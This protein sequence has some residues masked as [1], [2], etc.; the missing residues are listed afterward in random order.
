MTLRSLIALPVLL[1]A[2]VA[3]GCGDEE[4]GSPIPAG[5]AA[6]L[7]DQLDGIQR[8]LDNGSAGACN[9][10]LG[11]AK[12]PNTEAV[13]QQLA[14]LPED[15]DADVRDALQQSFDRLFELIDEHC[16]QLQSEQSDPQPGP[17]PDP[18]P[19]PDTTPEEE[20]TTE[21][22]PP[23]TEEEPPPTEEDPVDPETEELPPGEEN[24]GQGGGAGAPEDP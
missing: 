2:G 13:E 18:E 8:R 23:P 7:Q 15:V 10:I 4:K 21:E 6:A 22:E 19:T 5:Q 9:D 12:G 24:E 3:A 20:P 1:L 14:A 17:E 16:S 11:G